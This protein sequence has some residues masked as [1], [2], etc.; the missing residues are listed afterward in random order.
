MN[1]NFLNLMSDIKPKYQETQK[2]S[3]RKKCLQNYTKAYSN[4]RHSKKK[5]KIPKDATWGEKPIKEQR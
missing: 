5:K 1:E 2:T 3:S 4:F